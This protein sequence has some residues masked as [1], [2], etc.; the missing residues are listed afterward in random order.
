MIEGRTPMTPAGRPEAR[1]PVCWEN[2]SGGGGTGF[3]R[4]NAECGAAGGVSV[5]EMRRE[6]D[7]L[8][9]PCCT[10]ETVQ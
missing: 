7:I 9:A 8:P 6:T 1:P 3:R 10:G 4:M 5:Q 2:A